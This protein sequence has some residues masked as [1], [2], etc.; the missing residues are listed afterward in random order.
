MGGLWETGNQIGVALSVSDMDIL[1]RGDSRNFV[2]RFPEQLQLSGQIQGFVKGGAYF[3][4][5]MICEA[6]SLGGTLSL[7]R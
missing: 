7:R 4:S 6:G 2:E 3:S 1:A 5:R